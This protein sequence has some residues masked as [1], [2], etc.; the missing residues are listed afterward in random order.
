MTT[1]LEVV[2]AYASGLGIGG[3]LETAVGYLSDDFQNFDRDGKVALTKERILV[4]G[5]ILNASF[6]DYGFVLDNLREEGDAVI[7]TGHFEG[8][9]TA[10]LDLSAVGVGVIP[11]SGK[12]IVWP[13]ASA[14][15]TVEGGEIVRMEPYAGAAGLKA[16]LS[17]LGVG[18]EKNN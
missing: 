18:E 5:R 6:T 17:V 3:D 1:D 10:D 7:M 4:M 16:F 8:R 12:Q 2:S 9:H 13:E 14:K 11:A 15:I